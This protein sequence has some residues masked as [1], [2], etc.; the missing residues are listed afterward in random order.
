MVLSSQ[1]DGVVSDF[2]RWERLRIPNDTTRMTRQCKQQDHRQTA[3]PE[4]S[5]KKKAMWKELK[6]TEHREQD[7]KR[8]H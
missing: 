2:L 6:R 8:H 5:T 3:N 7:R 1:Q 4:C